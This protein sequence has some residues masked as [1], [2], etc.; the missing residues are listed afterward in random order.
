[1]EL[2]S[3]PRLRN[4]QLQTVSENTIKIC[5]ELTQLKAPLETL[6]QKLD[7]F[8]GGMTKE[9]ASAA[10]KKELD[11]ARDVLVSGFIKGVRIESA[12]PYTD[13]TSKEAIN[14]L[15]KVVNNYGTGIA[16]L[17][18]NEESAA[19]DNLLADISKLDIT[20]LADSGLARWI[21]LIEQA[22]NNFK[23]AVSDYISESAK[24]SA[25]ESATDVAPAL[26]DAL[27]AL[28][29]MIYAYLKIENSEELKEAYTQLQI[30]LESYK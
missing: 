17:S 7:L 19:L 1:M 9:Q 15:L 25:V 21:P 27:E 3:L 16:R 18:Y 23:E 10:S 20:P 13:T 5:A 26:L 2:L 8:K 22:N 11:N 6:T 4:H 28:Y 14:A 12:F 30:L 24:S 29:A